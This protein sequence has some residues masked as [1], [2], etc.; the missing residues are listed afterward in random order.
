[1]QGSEE[2]DAPSWP[3]EMLLLWLSKMI[4]GR[5][6]EGRYPK[7]A[8]VKQAHPNMVRAPSCIPAAIADS[9]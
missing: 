8:A 2:G 6:P 5:S 7:L 9:G 4:L 1:L 3:T